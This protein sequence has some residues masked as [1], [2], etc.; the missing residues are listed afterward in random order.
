MFHFIP[1]SVLFS[2]KVFKTLKRTFPIY[3]YFK[4]SF[5]I[6]IFLKYFFL[7]IFPFECVFFLFHVFFDKK[8]YG[9]Y[10]L[11]EKYFLCFNIFRVALGNVYF[12]VKSTFLFKCAFFWNNILKFY[13]A[14]TKNWLFPKSTFFNLKV[15][16][17]LCFSFMNTSF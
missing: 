7:A 14:S 13:F 1:K 4:E 5:F 16:S 17:K 3:K 8:Y 11:F 15:N 2:F 10:L 6:R 12:L 9:V